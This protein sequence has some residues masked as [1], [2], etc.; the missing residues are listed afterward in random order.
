MEDKKK[1]IRNI[2]K[3]SKILNCN[4]LKNLH[5]EIQNEFKEDLLGISKSNPSNSKNYSESLGTKNDMSL[6]LKQFMENQNKI[7]LSTKFGHK[8]V[9][10]FLKEKDKAMEEIEI[11]EEI[12]K[13]IGSENDDI[14]NNL[15]NNEKCN[16]YENNSNSHLLIFRG[17]FGKDEF[18]KKKNEDEHHHHH[19]H[20]HHRHHHH[21][22]HS[23]TNINE[24]NKNNNINKNP[25]EY[26]NKK[27]IIPI[28]C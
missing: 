9:E 2:Y 20:H 10:Q 4:G 28:K 8:Y 25:E 13:D 11:S 23:E 24:F 26:D 22:H 3:S 27:E 7:R 18:E 6:N 15:K 16:K 19:H 21:N 17:T 14:K 1:H 5:K 12:T